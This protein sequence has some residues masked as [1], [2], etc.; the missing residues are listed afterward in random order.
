[1][2]RLD[3]Y[4][5]A[6]RNYR[7]LT[8]ESRDCTSFRK[9]MAQADTENDEIVIT[10]NICT[11]DEEWIDAIERGLSFVEKAIK[12][13]RQFIYSNG[14]VI[15]I[16]KVK[17]V[18]KDS[19][20][21]L[22]KHSNLITKEQEGPDLIPDQLYSV[23]KLNDYAVYENRFLYMLLCYLRDFITERYEKILEISNKYD[24]VL[25]LQKTVVWQNRKLTYTVDLHEECKDDKHLRASNPAK[26][27]ID[28]ID[29]LL[30][31]VTS[32]LA[33]PLMEIAGKAAK[34]KPP[35]TKTNV[36]KMDNNF[37]GAVALYDYIVSYDKDGYSVECSPVNLAPFSDSLAE[38]LSEAGAM[39]S[40]LVYEYGLGLNEKL[41]ERYL[42]EEIK[43]KERLAEQRED[44][45]AILRRKLEHA[46]SSPEEYIL[47]AEKHI[48]LLQSDLRQIG[49][50]RVRIEELFE[51]KEKNEEKI[52]S[53]KEE[54]EQLQEQMAEEEQHHAAAILA[55]R[56]ESDTLV[57]E[58]VHKHEAEI[59]ELE[60]DCAQ[61]LESMEEI[62][63][64]ETEKCDEKVRDAQ[65]RLAE[66][67]AKYEELSKKYEALL[68][69]NRFCEA[70]LK[71]RQWKSGE[72][73]AE[74]AFTEKEDFDELERELEAF[75]NFYGDRWSKVKKKI[76]KKLL[77]YRALKGRTGKIDQP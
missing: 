20:R 71:G 36:L 25:K 18:S 59:H 66:S 58:Y 7:S 9:A 26:K 10:R 1:M 60:Q 13:E 28:R 6:L 62:M 3:I 11:V 41:K 5:R 2:N 31:A 4:Y 54:N 45:L 14:E 75:V 77:S 17:H 47:E 38:D 30:K 48:R 52:A 39:L 29:L 24:G 8:S 64:L 23:E 72:P 40:F 70:R 19:V 27:A 46:E 34:L 57:R 65:E 12:E 32:Y 16:E 44:Q 51:I 69:R 73:F 15:P 63:A 53:M 67:E 55:V 74:D 61:R 76:R 37:K 68:E 43:R 22:A 35:I 49:P 42:S 21:H 56:S 33:T 50:L